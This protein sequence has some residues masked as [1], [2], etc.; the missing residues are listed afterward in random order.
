VVVIDGVT[1]QVAPAL[2]YD[3]DG[4]LARGGQ[5]IHEAVT[6]AMA[7]PYFLASPPKST[8]RELFTPAF[9]DGFMSWCREVRPDASPGDLVAT[10]VQFTAT[11]IADSYR[12]FVP[13]PVGDVVISGGG[14]RNPAVVDALTQALAPTRVVRFDDLFFDSEAKEAVAFALLG[15]LHLQGEAGNVPSATG[16]RGPRVL[17]K[18]C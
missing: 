15:Y 7:H 6:R 18:R 9:I 1:R 11:S 10:A 13:E 4:Q 3:V 14:A 17:G 16:A 2:A 12:R 5:A 8:G